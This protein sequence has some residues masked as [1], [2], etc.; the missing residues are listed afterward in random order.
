MWDIQIAHH[1]TRINAMRSE[2][3]LGRNIKEGYV[4]SCGIQFGNISSLCEIDKIFM[5]AYGLAKGRTL[6]ALQNF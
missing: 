3:R 6:V 2:I 4:R 1:A 5:R